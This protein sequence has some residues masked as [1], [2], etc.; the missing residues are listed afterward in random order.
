VATPCDKTARAG[1]FGRQQDVGARGR[2]VLVAGFATKQRHRLAGCGWKDRLLERSIQPIQQFAYTTGKNA[3]DGAMIID[4]MD[5]LYAARFDGFCVVSSDSDFARLAARAREQGVTVCGFGERKTPRPFV[6]ACDKFV[7]V[8]VLNAPA[9]GGQ[10]EGDRERQGRDPARHAEERDRRRLRRKRLGRSWSR[11]L[12]HRE[13][14]AGI[15]RAKLRLR[16]LNA[17]KG[18]PAAAGPAGHDEDGGPESAGPALSHPARIENGAKLATWPRSKS[19]WA[20][21]A[22]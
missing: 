16:P 19:R 21:A 20:D 12:S 6:A 10:S 7:Y 11:R 1:T 9:G 14:I 17:R 22:S 18:S 2:L 8:D 15:R 5:L 3:A 13:A 4:A